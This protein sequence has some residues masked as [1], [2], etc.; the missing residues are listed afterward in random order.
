MFGGTASTVVSKEELSSGNN[1]SNFKQLGMNMGQTPR[2]KNTM[3]V[4][5]TFGK[6]ICV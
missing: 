3:L 6:K 4:P 2:K 1:C 5:I